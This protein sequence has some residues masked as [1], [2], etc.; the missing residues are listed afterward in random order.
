MH[1][2]ILRLSASRLVLGREEAGR[3]SLIFLLR[4]MRLG[5]KAMSEGRDRS[6]SILAD[7]S[8]ISMLT[9]RT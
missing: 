7:L 1:D 6:D 4:L 9:L 3:E 5:E 8:G 2:D